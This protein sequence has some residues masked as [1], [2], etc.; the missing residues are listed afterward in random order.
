MRIVIVGASD[1]GL[2][3]A[4]VFSDGEHDV[5]LIEVDGQKLAQSAKELD[6]GCHLSSGANVALLA[7]LARHHPDLL[8]ATSDRDELNL[9]ICTLAKSVGFARTMA[10]L[11]EDLYLNAGATDLKQLFLTDHIISPDR[12]AACELMRFLCQDESQH[13]THFS[14]GLVEMHKITLPEDWNATST[15]ISQLALPQ[16][17]TLAL[18]R[19]NLLDK[20]GQSHQQEKG[21]IFPHGTDT[22]FPSDEIVL[23][24]KAEALESLR[25]FFGLCK[26]KRKRVFIY[27]FS[28]VTKHLVTKLERAGIEL[29]VII[30]Q[31][32]KDELITQ[33][34]EENP[35]LILV[36]RSNVDKET[37]VAEQ[38]QSYDVFIAASEDDQ[39]NFCACLMAQDI[40]IQTVGISLKNPIME[41]LCQKRGISLTVS[42]SALAQA[43][44]LSLA[45]GEAISSIVS[46]YNE[47][48]YAMQLHIGPNNP[49]VGIPLM[50]LSRQL[51]QELLFGVI[52][53]K[54]RIEIAKGTS[55]MVPGD[56][57][58]ILTHPKHLPLLKQLLS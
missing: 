53:S 5:T 22:L 28:R 3:V 6:I 15:P 58:T 51:P 52:E 56:S 49:L 48:A 17:V 54:G 55:V 29:K 10:R 31:Q 35:Q 4:K 37:L 38:L 16:D 19:R 36:K 41:D 13:V 39:D 8:I 18:I 25:R 44:I 57:V 33:W 42:P 45:A 9:V 14:H 1:L 32:Q 27:G 21:L 7:D 43:E 40:G 26:R 11:K 30:D 2:H 12:L 20:D 24:G 23:F 34:A 47:G 46:L 50:H